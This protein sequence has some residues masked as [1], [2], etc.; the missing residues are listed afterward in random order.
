MGELLY[1]S[2]MADGQHIHT[3]FESTTLQRVRELRGLI[4]EAAPEQ[5]R[6]GRL[7]PGV[8]EAL[9]EAG[10]Y[11][12]AVPARFGGD[13]L[14]PGQ[15]LAVAEE[16]SS[17]D[18]STGW[19]GTLAAGNAAII[20]PRASEQALERVFATGPNP[21]IVGGAVPMARAREVDGGWAFESTYN[22]AS[23]CLHADWFVV[24]AIVFDGDGPRMT[25]RGPA[26]VAGILPAGQL[27]ITGSWDTLG[28]RATASLDLDLS[29]LVLPNEMTFAGIPAFRPRPSL[30]YRYSYG[31]F[32]IM[33]PIALGIARGALDAFIELAATKELR[34]VVM[35]PLRETA[36]VQELV[37]RCRG[38]LDAARAHLLWAWENVLSRADESG[39]APGDARA[40]YHVAIVQTVDTAV[41]VVAALHRALGTPVIQHGNPIE[42]ALR[43][44]H[45]AAQHIVV[46]PARY[47]SAGRV[48]LGL[49]PGTSMF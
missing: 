33:P 24:G 1:D 46:S 13:D 40:A 39:E 32:A 21:L 12:M 42:R 17:I 45:T 10:V 18:G 29:G 16:L 44:V 31:Y 9:R 7:S 26:T 4:A 20:V 38:R 2:G 22:F 27:P 30:L 35:G 34:P 36:Q 37:A 19:V 41:D 48:L 3:A 43:D 49:E 25:P 5:E 15:I 23:G 28:L 14:S 47:I 8:V 6:E 11:R